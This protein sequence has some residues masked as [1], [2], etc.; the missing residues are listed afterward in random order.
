MFIKAV[1]RGIA[2]TGL[3]WAGATLAQPAP[4]AYAVLSEM[5]RDLHVVTFQ[6]AVGSSLD[7]NQRQRF[8]LPGAVFEKLL[9]VTVR[10]KLAQAAPGAA[11]WLIAPL[12]TDLFPRLQSPVVGSQ[13]AIPDDLLE[14]LK[15]QKSTHLLLFTRHRGEADFEIFK[16]PHAG[17]GWIEGL[18]FYI[19]RL[20]LVQ[21]PITRITAPGFLTAFTYYRITL[22]DVAT[23]TVLKTKAIQAYEV[24]PAAR[25]RDSVNPWDAM[26][27]KEKVESLQRMI[28]QSIRALLPEMLPAP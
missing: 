7:N 18:G 20:F 17:S 3:C 23:R 6:A 5:A 11:V 2:F 4:R 13:I 1:L 9:L 28:Q 24:Q 16:G 12:D 10:E 14:G 15:A 27:S 22:V 8:D 21:D 25:A 19:D 26:N